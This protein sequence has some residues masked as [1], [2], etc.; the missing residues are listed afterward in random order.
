VCRRFKDEDL[1]ID[2]PP[3][4]ASRL[5]EYMR[6]KD[7]YFVEVPDDLDETAI[8]TAL[9]ELKALCREFCEK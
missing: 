7:D 9:S 3:E 6:I 8:G 5:K 2:K 4:E 1:Y